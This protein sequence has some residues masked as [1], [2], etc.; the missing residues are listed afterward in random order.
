M[1]PWLRSLGAPTE[2][3]RQEHHWWDRL[4]GK[5]PDLLDTSYR[6][7]RHDRPTTMLVTVTDG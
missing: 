7:L 6:R 2:I 1:T 5:L 4:T 3:H